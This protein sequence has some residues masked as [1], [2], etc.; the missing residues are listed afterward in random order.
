MKLKKTTIS[1]IILLVGL[2]VII[3]LSG[4]SFI[5][6]N[7][8]QNYTDSTQTNTDSTS[9]SAP[10]QCKSANN[11][12]DFFLTTK[13]NIKIA[14]NLYP[15]ENPIGW[16]VL[17]HMMPATKESWLGLA[18]KLQSLGYESLAIDLRGHGES[19]GGHNG[20][21]NFSDEEH[22]KSILDLETVVEY[23]KIRGAIPE[24]IIFI[25]ASIGANLSL[26][27]ISEHPE[28]KTAILLSPGL[29]YKGIKTEPM[30]EKL[31]EGQRV[32]F[33]SSRDDGPNAEQN[34]KLFD[35]TPTGVEKDLIIYKNSGHGTSMLAPYRNEI[36]GAGF[37]KE[38]PDL[39]SAIIKFLK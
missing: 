18:G 11:M 37:G 27:Y 23:F 21:M 19:D 13:D 8:A 5:M 22:Q 9:E 36:S 35:L 30:V 24:K 39:E 17:T 33:V 6:P 25:G 16:V 7:I 26:Q 20:F 32:L 2:V 14:T 31:K 10:K 29:N 3:S 28:F 4:L 12:E 1:A 15:V 38:E 34:Q